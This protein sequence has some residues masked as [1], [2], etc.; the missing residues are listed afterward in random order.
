ML[1]FNLVILSG[2]AYIVYLA[3]KSTKHHHK[4]HN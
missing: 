2:A 3:V 1:A 4:Q